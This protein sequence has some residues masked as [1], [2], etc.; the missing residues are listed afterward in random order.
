MCLS[1][2]VSSLKD[3]SEIIRRLTALMSQNNSNNL[4]YSGCSSNTVHKLERHL[5]NDAN[6]VAIGTQVVY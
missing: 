4:L 1:V 3:F 6:V 5:A 2:V